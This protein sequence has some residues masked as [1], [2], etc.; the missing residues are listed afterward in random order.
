MSLFLNLFFLI[1]SYAPAAAGRI[2]HTLHERGQF[3]SVLD[4]QTTLLYC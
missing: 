2:I 1:Q 3:F 4:A